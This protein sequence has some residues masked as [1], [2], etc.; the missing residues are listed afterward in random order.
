MLFRNLDVLTGITGLPGRPRVR[1]QQ[2]P[3]E[4]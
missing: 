2:A 1:D 3:L 4:L